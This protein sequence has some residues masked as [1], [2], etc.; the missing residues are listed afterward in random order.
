MQN[1]DDHEAIKRLD[2]QDT[3]TAT[4]MLPEQ[5]KTAWDEVN[6]LDLPHDMTGIK[7]IVFCGMGASIYGA[8]VLKAVLG[9]EMPYP[10]EIVTD[11]HLPIYVDKHT[12]VV[13]TSYSGT[14]EEILSCAEEAKAKGA[15]MI[16]LTHGGPL[17]QFARE[18]HVP[19]YIFDGQK[20]PSGV[21]RHGM[22][23]SILG[24]MGLMNKLGIIT[25]AEE[26]ITEA[27]TRLTEKQ[28][29]IRSRAIEDYKHFVGKIPVILAAEHLSGNAQIFRNQF[30]ETSKTF[31]N[32][33]LVPDL[34]HHL[35]EGLQF[36]QPSNL[37]FLTLTTENYTEKIRHRMQLTLDVVKQNHQALSVYNTEG[38]T[39]YD[40]FFEVLLYGSYLTLFLALHYDQNPAVNPWVDWFKSELKKANP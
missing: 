33:Y 11:Y 14:T 37:R 1:F 16:V 17:A 27:L 4:E 7:T 24:L 31:S 18:N 21:P 6:S 19:A 35:M 26:E 15:K 20:N 12:L 9:P 40:D 29:E 34:N 5:L 2:P 25:L 39:L 22:G 38:Q 36:P 3:S 32:Y 30:N 13:L 8:L 28:P 10:S 23:Y